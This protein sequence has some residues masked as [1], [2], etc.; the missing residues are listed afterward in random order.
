MRI[1]AAVGL[2]VLSLTLAPRSYADPVVVSSG[3]YTITW[4]EES[5]LRLIGAGFDLVALT[6]GG[7]QPLFA[8][9]PCA[10]GTSLSLTDTFRGVQEVLL[11]GIFNDRSHSGLFY[12]GGMS[13]TAGTITV[14]A[15]PPSSV[16]D[17]ASR[18]DVRM[19]FVAS[20][21]LTAYDN[22]QARGTPLF[23]GLFT[24]RG[25]ATA[26]LFRFPGDNDINLD[27]VRYDFGESAAVPEPATLTL[28][29]LGLTTAYAAR[30]R[31]GILRRAR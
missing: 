10:S 31:R 13:F 17:P 21:V 20:G 8:C 2:I 6:Q 28:V 1:S 4:D 24:G 19:S 18:A 16:G 3:F 22:V 14:P 15:L 7:G 26:T 27:H 23:S 11:P 9:H 12:T 25:T 30:R 5:D 29:G